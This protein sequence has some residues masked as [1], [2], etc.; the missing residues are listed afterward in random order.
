MDR[1]SLLKGALAGAVAGPGSGPIVYK[2]R[3]DTPAYL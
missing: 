2:A 1:R 3:I